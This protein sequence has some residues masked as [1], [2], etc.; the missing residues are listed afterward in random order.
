MGQKKLNGFITNNQ[1]RRISYKKRSAGLVAKCK[2]LNEYC[3]AEIGLVIKDE[4]GKF[5]YYFSSKDMIDSYIYESLKAKEK[6]E[7]DSKT[8]TSAI[9]DGSFFS[10]LSNLYLPGGDS[11]VHHQTDSKFDQDRKEELDDE[12]IIKEEKLND[13]HISSSFDEDYFQLYDIVLQDIEKPYFENIE[14]TIFD[15]IY[16]NTEKPIYDE[17]QF[18]KP[19]EEVPDLPFQ[20]DD[21]IDTYLLPQLHRA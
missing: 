3:N 1:K 7:I 19:S 14:E 20:E 11:D 9:Q 8:L 4:W 15:D 5:D 18:V 21:S 10:D 12:H 2:Q 16:Q 17:I 6:K 13:K